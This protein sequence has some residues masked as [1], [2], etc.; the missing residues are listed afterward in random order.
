MPSTAKTIDVQGVSCP[1][2]AVRVKQAISELSADELIEIIVDEGEA[3]IMVA[4]SINDAGHRIFK[5]E[6]REHSVS[7][8]AGKR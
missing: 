8:I 6:R 1:V 3:I 2:N 7:I 5:V 4:R